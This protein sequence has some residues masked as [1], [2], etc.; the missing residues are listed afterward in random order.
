MSGFKD[1][2]PPF[3]TAQ[4][5]AV[6]EADCSVLHGAM[7]LSGVKLFSSGQPGKLLIKPK[8]GSMV[9]VAD[10]SQ[11]KLRDLTVIKADEVELIKY[12]QDGLTVEIDSVSKMV[13][14]KNN[15]TSLSKLFAS[16]ADIISGITVSTPMGNSGT[17]LLPTTL[18]I[19]KFK[20]DFQSLL[21]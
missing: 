14:I 9:T 2:G 12:D 5:T 20:M 8:V 19:E 10:F 15:T 7:T 21:K 13:D 11:G 4:V 16:V 17:P 1:M 18:L 6:G 3:F